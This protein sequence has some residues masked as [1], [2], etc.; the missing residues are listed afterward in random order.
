MA[1][2][3]LRIR[4]PNNGQVVFDESDF[5]FR[6]VEYREHNNDEKYITLPSGCTK[7]NCTVTATAGLIKSKN[8]NGASTEAPILYWDGDK[9]V[10]DGFT[11]YSSEYDYFAVPSYLIFIRFN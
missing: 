3:A 4:N 7:S 10:N 8:N 6:I 11:Q 9:L 5:S 1:D 2:P